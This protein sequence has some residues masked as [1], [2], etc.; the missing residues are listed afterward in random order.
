MNNKE[1]ESKYLRYLPGIYQPEDKDNFLGRFLKA[2][3]NIL[4]AYSLPQV[5]IKNPAS[6]ASRLRDVKDPLSL[7]LRNLFSQETVSLLDGYD[8][9]SPPSEALINA[10]SVE[11]NNLLLKQI[12]DKNGFKQ[13]KLTDT[14]QELIE[15]GSKTGS[16]DLVL[17]NLSILEEAFPNDIGKKKGIEE[18][19]DCIQDYF[20]P[21]KTPLEFLSWL[22][23]WM[24][25][26]LKEEKDWNADN[27][28]KKRDLI[29]K[30]IPLYQKRG[31]LDGLKEYIKIY[32]GEDV[33]ISIFEFLDPFRV[34]VTSTVGMNT[35]V[36][37][38]LPYYFQ[39]FMELPMLD[40]VMLEKKKKAIIDIID[41]EKPA[42][43]YYVLVIQ[44][45]TMQIAYHS[46]VGVDTLL[47]GLIMGKNSD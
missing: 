16:N 23:G 27:A 17:L 22:A 38:G 47:G 15:T 39:V 12:Y 11:F 10:L 6:L 43:T 8:G 37:E 33:K 26:I 44:A 18:I 40:R 28:R 45:P 21:D 46:T 30:I 32:V 24:A 42:H 20:D 9:S 34:G 36:G 14:V 1:N 2:F 31:T 4:S 19:L 7:Y 29:A 5:D 35:V 13:V 41:Q 3:E 25:L